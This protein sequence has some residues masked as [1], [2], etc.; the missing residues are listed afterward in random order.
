MFG[1]GDYSINQF[2]LIEPM[3][4][5]VAINLNSNYTPAQA[6]QEPFKYQIVMLVSR[7]ILTVNPSVV[8]DMFELQTFFENFSYAHDLKRFRPTI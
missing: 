3:Y 7:V 5:N 4:L 1:I 6:T 2:N 8:K